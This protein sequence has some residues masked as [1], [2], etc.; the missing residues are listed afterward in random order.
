M[1]RSY[2]LNVNVV[3]FVILLANFTTTTKAVGETS[4]D[5]KEARLHS[6]ID[7]KQRLVP[8]GSSS[9]GINAQ[10]GALNSNMNREE[11]L[12]KIKARTQG[13]SEDLR[14]MSFDGDN[15]LPLTEKLPAPGEP[16]PTPPMGQAHTRNDTV[17][18]RHLA[19]QCLTVSHLG[20]S[21]AHCIF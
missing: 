7:R 11:V 5:E 10:R 9:R 6:A 20:N 17:S 21:I 16:R 18:P 4:F 15:W 12:R 13:N 8:D 19:S 1:S 3:I 2:G 14:A